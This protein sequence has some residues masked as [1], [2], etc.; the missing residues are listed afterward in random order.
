[1][2]KGKLKNGFVNLGLLMLT[3]ALMLLFSEFI[4]RILF[5]DKIVLFPKYQTNAKY[6]D[7]TIR[8]LRP[9]MKYTHRSIDGCFDFVTNNKG[10]RSNR[11]IEYE[12]DSNELRIFCLGDSHVLGIE[13]K[14]SQV[15]TTVIEELFK[16]ANIKATAINTGVTGFGTAEELV[17]LENEGYKYKPNFVVLG[18]W[19]NDFSGNLLSN[20]YKV[21]NDSLM[22]GSYIHLP[23]VNIQN[24]IY[25]Y[26][27]FHFLGEN[28]YL[29]AYL[30]NTIWK[31]IKKIKYKKA[32]EE[33]NNAL[34][35][36]VMEERK[37]FPD[38]EILLTKKLIS[39][40][41]NFCKKQNIQFIIFDI[42]GRTL[43]S[44]IPEELVENFR[45]NCD[46]LFYAPDLKHDFEKLPKVH[47]KHG[48]R[49]ISEETHDLFAHKISEYIKDKID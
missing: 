42:P 40:M 16:E 28:S 17:L 9:N 34:T 7:F 45:N 47:V 39:R 49:H 12:K 35:E 20:L 10:F 44:S 21:E 27:I 15:F 37:E 26:K 31:G 25:E 13:V 4:I 29:Y 33:G 1:M 3:T 32:E 6:G 5:K 8:R 36:Y 48:H 19:A 2:K 41:Y 30:F 38:Y 46:T 14:Q 18:F 22:V 43:E 23:G 11:D 24:A